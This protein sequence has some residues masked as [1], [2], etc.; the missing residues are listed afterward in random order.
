MPTAHRRLRFPMQL[1]TPALPTPVPTGAP[2]T[3]CLLASS[4]AARPAG[5]D[6]PARWVSPRE[7]AGGC[8]RRLR[9][10][11]GALGRGCRF[12]VHPCGCGLCSQGSGTGSPGHS[13]LLPTGPRPRACLRAA[14]TPAPVPPQTSTSVPPTR[15]RRAAPAWTRW[16]ASSASAP[17]SGWGPP[18][19]WVR[20]RGTCMHGPW[21][22]RV[23][24]PRAVRSAAG[25]AGAAVAAVAAG[26]RLGAAGPGPMAPSCLVRRRQ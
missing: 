10:V 5:V 25:A 7:A 4:A 11:E 3:R 18:A 9:G 1:S 13:A 15:A 14:H 20:P 19:G 2:A 21:G 12:H 8:S 24:G 26:G 17:N 6:P 16:T 22:T 23:H